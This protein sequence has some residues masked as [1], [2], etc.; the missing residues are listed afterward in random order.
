MHDRAWTTDIAIAG[1]LSIDAVVQFMKLW[2]AV[3]AVHV[4]EGADVFRWK[5]TASGAFSS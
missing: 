1:E 4:G 2:A 3:E 5:W